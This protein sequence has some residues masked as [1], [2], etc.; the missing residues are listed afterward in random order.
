MPLD[1]NTEDVDQLLADLDAPEVP[2]EVNE[3]VPP[4]EE[5]PREAPT[6]NGQEWEFETGGKKI[7]PE[8]REKAL[9]WMSQ[10]HSYSQRMAELNKTHAQR[11]AEVE[12][13]VKATQELEQRFNPYKEIDEYVKKDPAWWKHVTDSWNS[14]EQP[15]IDPALE[16][17]LKPI[18]E[19]LGKF[20]Q[21]LGTVEQQQALEEQQKADQALDQEISEI[22]KAHPNIDLSALDPETGESLEVRICKHAGEIGTR[23]FKAA[24]RDYLHD[25]LIEDARATGRQAVTKDKESQIR[26]GIL[27]TTQVPTKTPKPVNTKLPWSDPAFDSENILKEFGYGG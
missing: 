20:E 10:G 21:F 25:K 4:A 18:Q 7:F 17:L 11:M 24:F 1:E 27:G 14:R 15:K 9:I 5:A 6:W 3:A 8:S 2:R 19:K 22:R 23:S 26:K 13:K 12:A 16:T